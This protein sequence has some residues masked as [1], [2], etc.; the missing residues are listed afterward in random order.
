MWLRD[1]LP[2]Q[3][4]CA[5]IMTYGYRANVLSDVQTG[6]LRTFSET[7]LEELRHVRED[8]GVRTILY[9]LR[10]SMAYIWKIGSRSP[11]YLNRIFDGRSPR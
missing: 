9:L 5:R 3:L 4:P 2:E 1:S 6:R 7:F 8:S 11:P 10:R